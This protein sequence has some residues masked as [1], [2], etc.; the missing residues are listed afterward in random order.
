MFVTYLRLVSSLCGIRALSQDRGV[1]GWRANCTKL[2]TLGG[3]G[4]GV[5]LTAAA[6]DGIKGVRPRGVIKPLCA[7][8]SPAE[9]APALINKQHERL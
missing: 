7:V 2:E 8:L 5:R 1:G 6:G 3:L 4:G 9:A